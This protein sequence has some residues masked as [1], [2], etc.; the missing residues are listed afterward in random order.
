MDA[1]REWCERLAAVGDRLAHPPFPADTRAQGLRH[2]AR[3]VLVALEGELAHGDA[4]YP[5][6]HRYEAPWSQWGGPNPDNVYIRARIDPAATYR[7]WGDVTGLRAAIF[8]LCDGD[9]HL[10]KYGVFGERTLDSLDVRSDGML[11]LW[12][13]PRR[14]DG[15]WIEM[16]RD[17]RIF[18]IRQYQCD[19]ER[20]SIASFAIERVDTAGVAPPA[21]SSTA[22]ADA[23]ARAAEWI[24][25]SIEYWCEYVE[26]AR[27]GMTA[28]TF[29][30]PTTPKGGAPN[31]AYGSGWWRL[32]AD[33]AL[34]VESAV[35]DADYWGWTV[36]HRYWLDSGDFAERQTSLNLTQAHFDHDGRVR[37]VVAG[38]DPGVPNWI[39]T[40][41]RP[42]GMLVYRYIGA[43]T[44]PVPDAR[45]VPLREV[46][47]VLPEDHPT[48]TPDQRRAA[49]ARRRAA[50]LAR[51]A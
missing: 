23:L 26:R 24:E 44:Q 25:R 3:Q 21:P 22:V 32:G 50:A 39:D 30:P 31:I 17:A 38:T 46:G 14:H 34:V 37:L 51:Y 41:G 6:F 29:T 27:S 13:S 4:A 16:H 15:N 47:A 7:V 12:L 45:V 8:S 19:W 10:G 42:E 2:L 35:P 49:L 36:H 28:N 48:V 9:M 1:W 18:M 20:D 40:E 43:R 11:E 33:E 5:S